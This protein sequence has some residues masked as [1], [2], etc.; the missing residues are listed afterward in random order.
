MMDS[1]PGTSQTEEE[2]DTATFMRH[3]KT[4]INWLALF[5]SNSMTLR[6]VDDSLKDATWS[7]WFCALWTM[8]LRWLLVSS[9]IIKQTMLTIF[10]TYK[11]HPN[12]MHTSFHAFSKNFHFSHRKSTSPF[13][14]IQVS[15]G[16]I[17]I[18]KML[19]NCLLF[20][21]SRFCRFFGKIL[22][23]RFE[24]T[25]ENIEEMT[26]FSMLRLEIKPSKW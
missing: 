23:Y 14:K 7:T 18:Q 4:D 3:I 24:K 6:G 1:A 15:M 13:W 19:T 11:T 26:Q 9:T 5:L 10:Y 8:T 16:C 12:L 21:K 25:W 20:R 22:L 17:K 2:N